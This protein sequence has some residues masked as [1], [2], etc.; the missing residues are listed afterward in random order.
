[1]DV[2]IRKNNNNA[3]IK[4]FKADVNT[5]PSSF[6]FT[7]AQLAALF[8]TPIVLGDSYDVGVDIYTKNGN[9]YEAFPVTGA[10]YGS[11]GVANQPNFSPTARYSAV[12]AY[13]AALFPTGNYIVLQDDWEDYKVGDIVTLTQID[14]T[15]ISFKYAAA[16]A[17]AIVITINPTTNATS[18]GPPPQ[19]YGNYGPPFGDWSVSSVAGHVDNVVLPCSKEIGVR[20]LHSSSGGFTGGQ[21]TIRFRKQ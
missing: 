15:H 8:G 12:C 10:A 20:L 2:V 9:K 13:N 6:T 7:A 14:A 11:T 3:N 18:V 5:F 4:V 19:V 17:Q 16:S 1:M 21:N